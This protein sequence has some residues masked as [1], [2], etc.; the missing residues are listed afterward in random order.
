MVSNYLKSND[1]G[2][3]I[4]RLSVGLI[5]LP[6]GISKL[7]NG[8]DWLGGLLSNVSLP[9][10][11]KYGV[12]IGEIVAPILLVIGYRTRIAAL[13][14][15]QRTENPCVLGSIPSGTTFKSPNPGIRWFRGF[16]FYS[17]YYSK[18]CRKL[19]YKD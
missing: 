15:E 2:I 14:V 17:R 11:M 18:I 13:F 19:S 9:P 10:I 3:L 6:H 8:V 5:L 7:I 12:Y 4:I 16:L 1:I